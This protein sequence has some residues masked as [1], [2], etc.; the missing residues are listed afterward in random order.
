MA[1]DIFQGGGAAQIAF[2]FDDVANYDA[3]VN[4]FRADVEVHVLGATRDGLAQIAATLEGRSNVEALYLV[5]HGSQGS[6]D[7]GTLT[8][9]AGNIG[10]YSD[11]L[12]RIGNALAED[13]DI[14]LYGCNVADS[15]LGAQFV[16]QI[17]QVTGA[18]V[19]ASI[20][21]TGSA[22]RGGNW[23]LEY[24]QGNVTSDGALDAEAVYS[25]DTLLDV[26]KDVTSTMNTQPGNFVPGFTLSTIE[27]VLGDPENGINGGIYFDSQKTSASFTVA[28]NG[29]TVAGF[30]LTGMTFLKPIDLQPEFTVTIVGN[31]AGGGIATA[32]LRSYGGTSNFAVTDGFNDMTGLTSFD[33]TMALTNGVPGA[34]AWDLTFDAFTVTI[35]PC[36][37]RRRPT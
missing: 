34:Y 23:T 14:L 30:D 18:D 8:L 16:G 19:A 3:L 36:Q 24:R 7:L 26:T 12:G 17:A 28:A 22:A 2:V 1:T 6:L 29:V 32:Q 15:A 21:L 35:S 33:V 10:A 11:V 4:A 20:N 13:G 5:G 25:L 9:D 27:P 37:P 31:K